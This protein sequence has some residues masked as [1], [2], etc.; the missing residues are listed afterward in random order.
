MRRCIFV[1]RRLFLVFCLSC[2]NTTL[3]FWPC[4]LLNK[5]PKMFESND[6]LSLAASWASSHVWS[7][8]FFKPFGEIVMLDLPSNE[9]LRLT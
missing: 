7:N 1:E 5:S 6:F 3:N 9:G 2:L 8:S 4:Q